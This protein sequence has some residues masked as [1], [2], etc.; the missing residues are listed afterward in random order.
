MLRVRDNEIHHVMARD[1]NLIGWLPLPQI[2]DK[3]VLFVN[4]EQNEAESA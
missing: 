1:K 3:E 4:G 2:G